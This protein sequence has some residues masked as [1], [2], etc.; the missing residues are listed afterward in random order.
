MRLE[1]L[2]QLIK[3]GESEYVEFKKTTGQRTEATKT[4]CALLNGLGGFIFFGI[5]DKKKREIIGQQVTAKTLEDITHELRRIEPPVF[6]EI[7]T[8]SIGNDKVVIA[9]H[10]SGKMGTYCYDGR[11]YIRHGPTTQIMPRGEYEKRILHKFHAH[12]RWENEFAPKWVS[13][14]DLDEE[15]IHATLQNAVKLGRM[16]NPTHTDSES[17]LCGFKTL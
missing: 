3:K 2:Q 14:Q 11:P 5:S 4:I 7:E 9:I 16:K 8:I 13:V 15:E 6:P 17:I 1:E 10:I 12:R